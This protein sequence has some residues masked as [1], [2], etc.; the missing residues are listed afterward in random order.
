MWK[1]WSGYEKT[2]GVLELEDSSGKTLGVG[3]RAGEAQEWSGHNVV[4]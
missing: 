3:S 2:S 1:D 4:A